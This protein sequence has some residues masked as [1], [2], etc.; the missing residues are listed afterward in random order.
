[1]SSKRKYWDSAAVD[2]RG[3]SGGGWHTLFW[4]S[5]AADALATMRF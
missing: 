2:S 1:M 5:D 4:S 3:L